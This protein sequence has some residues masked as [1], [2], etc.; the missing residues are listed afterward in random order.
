MGE[1]S[2]TC[3]CGRQ[4]SILE[5]QLGTQVQ[6][7]VCGSLVNAQASAPPLPP[8]MPPPSQQMPYQ[9]QMPHARGPAQRSGMPG[10]AIALIVAIPVCLVGLAV[11]VMLAAIMLPALSRARE[12]ARRASCA[13][14]LKQ[15]GIVMMMNANEHQGLFPAMDNEPGRLMFK[16]EDVMPEY[17]ND[18]SV[19]YCPSDYDSPDPSTQDSPEA[20]DDQSYYY[21]NYAMTNMDQAYAFAELYEKMVAQ[22]LEFD[23]DLVQGE[24]TIYRITEDVEEKSGLSRSEIPVMFDRP[25]HHLPGGGNVLFMDGHVEFIRMGAKFPMTEEFMALMD[26]LDQLGE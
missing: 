15:M 8:P 23:L 4:I 7:P 24:T 18:A 10:W 17:M 14:N 19:L 2:I 6:C 11:L 20:V 16:A 21:L 5:E 13:N 26:R 22:G 25:G 1:L 3:N 9:Q 12:A